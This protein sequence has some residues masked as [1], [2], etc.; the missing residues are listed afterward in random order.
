MPFNRL[1][2]NQIFCADFFIFAVTRRPSLDR[3]AGILRI[4]GDRS[5]NQPQ[6]LRRS[7]AGCFCIDRKRMN[8]I[9]EFGA[10]QAV[11]G[12]MPIDAALALEDFRY[13][14][15]SEVSFSGALGRAGAFDHMR[16]SGVLV[17]FVDHFQS[18]RRKSCL[19]FFLDALCRAGVNLAGVNLTAH[20]KL[21]ILRRQN[22][23][24]P[25]AQS[26]KGKT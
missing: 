14:F 18:D 21:R 16:M 23:T 15:H 25:R 17:R 24:L 10:Q 6:N 8:A 19:Q 5:A 7:F 1:P 2:G 20:H 9:I 3:H 13:H 4:N 12:P 26:R 22:S 11:D